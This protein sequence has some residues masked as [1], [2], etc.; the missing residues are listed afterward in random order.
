MTVKLPISRRPSATLPG[1]SRPGPSSLP[2]DFPVV[3]PQR[4]ARR[5]S[6]G[7]GSPENTT[8][9]PDAIPPG[10]GASMVPWRMG[11]SVPRSVEMWVRNDVRHG[12]D[13]TARDI[14]LLQPRQDFRLR[15][16]ADAFLDFGAGIGNIDGAGSVVG[17]ARV[18][19][20]FRGGQRFRQPPP[21]V[22][23]GGGDDQ[24]GVGGVVQAGRAAPAGIAGTQRVRPVARPPPGFP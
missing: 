13:W 9:K 21:L 1:Q 18:F 16:L 8:G 19:Q 7:S 11:W 5:A 3:H 12:P 22:V 20:E 4:W 24:V 23:A 2:V 17:E 10:T 15:H 6:V 14:G